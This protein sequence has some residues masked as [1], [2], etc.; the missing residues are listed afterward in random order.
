MTNHDTPSGVGFTPGP[1][2]WMGNQYGL[3]LAT[4]HSGRKYVMGFRRVGMQGAQPVFRAGER[5]VPAADLVEFEVGDGTARGF[6][7][8]R[9]NETVYRYDVS[10]ID[11]A[12]ARLIAAAPDL[13]EAL[14]AMLSALR[15]NGP[16]ADG[17]IDSSERHARAALA[18]ASP[19]TN[20]G[21]G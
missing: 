7:A 16:D 4:T 11:N 15:Y 21:A 1:W 10:G 5:L 13:F 2:A 8:G 6:A 19:N 20:G 9:A 18:K 12:D 17:F 3:Y 14:I